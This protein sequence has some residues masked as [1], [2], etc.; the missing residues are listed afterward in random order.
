ME[1]LRRSERSNI[2]KRKTLDTSHLALTMLEFD[3][4]GCVSAHKPTDDHA[5]QLAAHSVGAEAFTPDTALSTRPTCVRS[6]GT[7]RLGASRDRS[8]AFPIHL[9]SQRDH[10]G[11]RLTQNRSQCDPRGRAQAG[12]PARSTHSLDMAV[13]VTPRH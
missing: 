5:G 8:R 1:Q 13:T 4:P 11:D 10:A 3:K 7:A 6:S 9:R 12:Q 2:R